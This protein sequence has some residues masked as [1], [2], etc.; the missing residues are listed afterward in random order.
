MGYG[1][2]IPLAVQGAGD[3]VAWAN[4][5]RE[6]FLPY[7]GLYV[8]I[9]DPDFGGEVGGSWHTALQNAV[10]RIEQDDTDP[11]G[12]YGGT[13][14]L[15][16]RRYGLTAEVE[17]SA[18][19]ALRILG[20]GGGRSAT[21][22]S[23]GFGSALYAKTAGM[24]IIDC[25]SSGG[26]VNHHGPLFENVTFSG[27][28]QKTTATL[29]RILNTNHWG[30]LNCAF[31]WGNDQ[32]Y[33]DFDAT[34]GGDPGAADVS[35]GVMLRCSF[36]NYNNRALRLLGGQGKFYDLQFFG[37]AAGSWAIETGGYSANAVF[38]GLK[39]DVGNNG[40]WSKGYANSFCNIGV[41]GAEVALRIDKD[42]GVTFSGHDNLF[43]E[44]HC[45]G[46]TS[47][48]IGIDITSTAGIN[49]IDGFYHQGY[50]GT[51]FFQ[52]ASGGKWWGTGMFTDSDAPIMKLPNR[53]GHPPTPQGGV[54][55]YAIGGEGYMKDTG[56]NQ[57]LQT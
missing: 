47:T 26:A 33:V 44:I 9:E 37:G 2:T 19:K 40:I 7:T 38:Q 56:G 57:V 52:D 51:N 8:H 21:D 28:D 55:L 27:V 50:T 46:R 22:E 16:P 20:S 24:R 23:R 41:E 30:F 39:L 31:I 5:V 49:R 12:T 53:S 42:P 25:D 14:I 54:Y 32:V 43:Q 1:R 18:R 34:P 3:P 11:A 29:V 4:E 36:W 15:G 17:I 13:V 48:A 10:N 35:Y 45:T 6:W